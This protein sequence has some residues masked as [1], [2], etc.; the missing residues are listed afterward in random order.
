MRN[1]PAR[2]GR[3]KDAEED[4]PPWKEPREPHPADYGVFST[5]AGQL[6]QEYRVQDTGKE[7]GSE[8]QL[9]GAIKRLVDHTI[10][11]RH[12]SYGDDEMDLTENGYWLRRGRQAEDYLRDVVYGGVDGLAYIRSL[13]EFLTPSSMQDVEAD[14]I[15]MEVGSLTFVDLS[16]ILS[17]VF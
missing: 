4:I 3:D 7:L 9:S 11:W 5:L 1:A 15:D 16:P 10:S 12:P 17:L 8:Y 6:A 13:A 2:R 14:D